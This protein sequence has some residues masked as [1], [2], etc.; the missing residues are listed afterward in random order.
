MLI[1]CHHE[2][3][4]AETPPGVEGELGEAGAGTWPVA[5]P[6]ASGCGDVPARAWGSAS[7]KVGGRGAMLSEA[8]SGGTTDREREGRGLVP[9]VMS[10]T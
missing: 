10:R 1:A 2:I 5:A 9:A 7:P 8:S 3:E 6:L 4:D